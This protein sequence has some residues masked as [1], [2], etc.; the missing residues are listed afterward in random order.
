MKKRTN[1]AEWQ[2][3]TNRWRIRVQKNGVMKSF[4]SSTPGRTGQREANAK[5]DAWLDDSIRD[6]RKKV[7]VLYAE[8]L[9][10]LSLTSGTSYLEQCTKYG[11][12]YL[13]P[14]IGNL[15]IE[16]L[17]EGD[18]QKAIDMSFKKRCLKKERQRSSLNKPLS[19]KTLM[20]IRST[21]NSFLKWC[22]KNRYT[23]LNPELTIP[24]NA[25]MGEK[26]ILQPSGLRVL[27]SVDTRLL[28]SKRVFDDYI[29]AYRFAVSTGVRP[30]EL[31][32]LWYGDIKGNTVNLRRSINTHEEETTGKNENSIRSFDMCQQAREAYEA[33]VQFLKDSGVEL[34]YN[35]PLFQIPCQRSLKRRWEKYQASNGITPAVTLYE[36]R[37]TFVSME[38]GALTDGQLKMLVGHSKNMDTFGVYRHEIKGQREE[39]AEA[40]TAAINKAHG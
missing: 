32:G 21:A 4:Y 20:T 31:V 25:R 10:D 8:W 30:G 15:R 16:E 5:A 33:Q 13:L 1:T 37:H 26:K 18:L 38:A 7:S 3:C 36:M 2:E 17:T 28:Y 14:V 39:L 19:R 22:R 35:T 6:G 23:T 24:K 34:N 9:E 40:T 29:Y 12:Y 11:D 27:F